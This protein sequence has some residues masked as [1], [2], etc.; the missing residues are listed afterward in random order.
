MRNTY[1]AYFEEEVLS[2]SPLRLVCLLY[3]K[4]I[5]ELRNARAFLAAGKVPE[6]CAAIS[7]ACDVLAELLSSLDLANGGDTAVRLNELYSYATAILV[8][9]NMNRDDSLI[10]EAL[11]LLVTLHEGWEGIAAQK[12]APPV[13]MP[14]PSVY[15]AQ[16]ESM[17][18]S[19]SF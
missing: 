7:K 4:A 11:G 15:A 16:S 18:Q 6:R 10:A 5:S 3:G 14:N 2:A 9:A 19:W 13:A 17:G 12:I 8:R 1:N